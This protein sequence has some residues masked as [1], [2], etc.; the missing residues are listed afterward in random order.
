MFPDLSNF[1]ATKQTLHW[2]SK[3]VGVVP[4]VHAIPHEKWWHISLSVV[5]DGLITKSMAL[6]DGGVFYLKMNL[7]KHVVELVTSGGVMR[8]FE[9]NAGISSTKFGNNLLTTLGDLGLSGD[10]PTAKFANDDA[11]AYDEAEAGKWWQALV[12][13][14]Q[15]FKQH[16]ANKG[17]DFGPVQLWSHGFDIATEIFGTRMVE[18]EEHGKVEQFPSQLNLGFSPG[19]P[20]HPAPYFYSNPFPFEEEA[21]L[22]VELPAFSQWHTTSWQGSIL[23]YNTL[24]NDPNASENLLAY[25]S[26]VY[27]T[28]M[29]TLQK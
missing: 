15:L 16:Q 12:Q 1:E 10:Y 5:P 13:V 14:D 24:V 7:I 29:P 3:A 26:A 23:E 25:A 9:M 2:Y 18:A 27:D 22:G 28:A 17:G 19:E 21:L 20:S 4:R 11:R 6:P 8:M